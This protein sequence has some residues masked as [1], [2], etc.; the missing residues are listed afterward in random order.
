M[1]SRQERARLN[2][3][4]ALQDLG[5]CSETTAVGTKDV[6]HVV[7]DLSRYAQPNTKVLQSLLRDGLIKLDLSAPMKLWITSQGSDYL[8]REA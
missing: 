8:S 4:Q 6:D 7:G 5:A 1:S 3:L 2:V